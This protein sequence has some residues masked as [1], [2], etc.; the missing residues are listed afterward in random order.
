MDGCHFRTTH[1]F[2]EPFRLPGGQEVT[3][4]P[5]SLEKQADL[6]VR[7]LPTHALRP[8]L[9]WLGQ[10]GL[11]V[12]RRRRCDEEKNVP[13]FVVSK[14]EVF[15]TTAQRFRKNVAEIAHVRKPAATN[16]RPNVPHPHKLHSGFRS[17]SVSLTMRQKACNGR[18][19]GGCGTSP[20]RR[21][22]RGPA[23]GRSRPPALAGGF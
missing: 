3:G 8:L 14:D 6:R 10:K 11:E 4:E 20:Q 18:R 5:V 19:S 23:L 2:I 9:G 22:V 15:P 17:S 16:L 7:T 12:S 21:D 13:T 1:L